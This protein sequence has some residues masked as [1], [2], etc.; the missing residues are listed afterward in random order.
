M[1]RNQE[2]IIYPDCYLEPDDSE[3]FESILENILG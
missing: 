3:G 1:F 2:S